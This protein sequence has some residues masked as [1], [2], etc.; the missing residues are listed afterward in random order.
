MANVL[1]APQRAARLL[2]PGTLEQALQDRD[3]PRRGVWLAVLKA[4]A[5]HSITLHTRSRR[6]EDAHGRARITAKN[7]KRAVTTLKVA[8][9]HD[10]VAQE[11]PLPASV[12]VWVDTLWSQALPVAQ[13][14]WSLPGV[15]AAYKEPHVAPPLMHAIR[16]GCLATVRMLLEA[17]VDVD[18][19]MQWVRGAVTLKPSQA[20]VACQEAMVAWGATARSMRTWKCIARALAAK[21]EQGA[22]SLRRTASRRSRR[23]E[24]QQARATTTTT[25]KG[26]KRQRLQ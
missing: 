5:T 24:Q 21:Q 1:T 11:V 20:V 4:C 3:A 2:C 16:G 6:A 23:A 25:P 15:R 26:G 19:R 10:P 22:Y 14:L 12:R 8:A 9:A 17:G 7:W 18:T 13:Y